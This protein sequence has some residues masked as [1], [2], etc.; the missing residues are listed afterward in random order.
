[1]IL[2]NWIAPLLTA[3]FNEPTNLYTDGSGYTAAREMMRRCMCRTGAPA[4]YRLGN[5]EERE[6]EVYEVSII[7]QRTGNMLH[8]FKSRS[9]TDGIT[10]RTLFHAAECLC[11]LCRMV[12]SALGRLGFGVNS[13]INPAF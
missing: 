10:K 11:T 3:L 7:Y 9:S 8:P 5:G 4:Y 12:D 13:D 2:T 1:M 6:V